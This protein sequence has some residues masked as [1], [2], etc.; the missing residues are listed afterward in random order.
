VLHAAGLVDVSFVPEEARLEGEYIHRAL[1]LEHD[2]D[3]DDESLSPRLRDYVEAYRRLAREL[4]LEPQRWETAVAD[5][6]VGYAGTF[7]LVASIGPDLWILDYKRTEPTFV[8]GIQLSAYRRALVP[9]YTPQQIAR[10]RRG[11]ITWT[12]DGLEARLIPYPIQT[13]FLHEGRFLAA[14]EI[15]RCRMELGL[16]T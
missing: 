7:D 13:N 6:S 15:F 4:R 10:M 5:L 2:G 11:V 9:L 3:L 14:L 12:T 8:A 16:L 1:A